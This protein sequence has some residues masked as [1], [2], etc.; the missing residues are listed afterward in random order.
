MEHVSVIIARTERISRSHIIAALA[1]LWLAALAS[2]LL[3]APA[4]A[5]V[6]E[7][8][9]ATGPPVY[10][11]LFA[12][13][14]S[15]QC[16]DPGNFAAIRRMATLA[17]DEVNAQGGI[18]GRRVVTRLLD[19]LRDDRQ[20]IANMEEALAEPD[21]IGMVG[22]GNSN[23]A[24]A[25]FT[26]LGERIGKS[27]VPFL[28][29]IS[30]TDL[31]A[32]HA[33]V[34]SSQLSQDDDRVP[35]MARFTRELGFDRPAFVGTKGTVFSEA[36]GDGLR[37]TL[38][39]GKLVAD[40]RLT[41]VEEKLDTA[42]V[43][44]MTAD[45][46]A[47]RP[48]LVYLTVG[49]DRTAD[50]MRALSA[51]GITPALFVAGRIAALPPEIVAAWP[52]ALYQLTV[53]EMPEV[54]NARLRRLIAADEPTNWIFEGARNREAEGW[55]TGACKERPETLVP[56]PYTAENMRALATGARYADMIALI[57]EAARRAPPEASVSGLRR[58]V[59]RELS[60]TYVVGRGA[61]KGLF[62]NWSFKPKSRTAARPTLVVIK[63]QG[64][65]RTQLAPF[66]LLRGR[67]G[68]LR[69][70]PTLYIDVDLI[71]TSRVDDNAKTFFAEFYLSMS[72]SP[73]ADIGRL[74]FANAF[75]DPRTGGRE[76][77][78]ETIHAGGPSNAYPETMK[79]YKVAGRF[80]FDPE[81]SRYPFDRQLF[82]IDVVPKSGDQPFLV[83]PPPA[84]LRDDRVETDGWTVDGK[85]VASEEDFVPVVDA[86][87]HAPSVVPFYRASF[88]WVMQRQTTDYYLRVVVPLIFILIVAYLSIFIPKSHFEAIVTIQVTALLS[89]VALYLAIPQL[90][91]DT[92]TISDRIFLFDYMMVSLMIVIS[93]LRINRFVAPRRWLVLGLDILHIAIIPLMVLVVGWSVWT[94][95]R[96]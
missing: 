84:N 70:V 46:V 85:Y 21:L 40:H 23:R 6:D 60:E 16:F 71:S 83:Q 13:S 34:F 74:E 37:E 52:N 47:K 19:D 69:R 51:A 33:N 27:G 26:A 48:D 1:V 56:T 79:I 50:I 38:G 22:L 53:D 8:E 4:R 2:A 5:A 78:I 28:S 96:A 3:A 91:N 17:A 10:I 25:V 88:G 41:L 24:K 67:D 43:D 45:L 87:T 93:I 31:F 95:G 62:E 29:H 49:T 15:D 89:A 32:K 11:A 63:P 61:F 76:I 36:L 80:L 68:K 14:R 42:S 44:A 75:L 7:A 82:T 54:D 81:L 39:D 59:V 65:E 72:N 57:A 66:Q 92:A 94:L 20:A 35:V 73:Q 12:G 58:A 30:V 77:S 90:D 55:K 18:H 64:I 9:A 86:Y